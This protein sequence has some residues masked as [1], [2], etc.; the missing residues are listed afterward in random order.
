M[1]VVPVIDL[2]QGEVV[3]ARRGERARYAPLASRLCPVSEPLAVVDC[4]LQLYAWPVLYL[5]DLDAIEGRGDH[6]GQVE[7][8][9]ARWPLLELWVDAG[10]RTLE[11]CRGLAR[12]RP[13]IG[14][15]SCAGAPALR[16]A[17]RAAAPAGALLSLDW[18]GGALLGP[19]EFG[20]DAAHWP[21]EVL[22]MELDR[23]G[24][25]A[26]PDLERLRRLRALAGAHR[27]LYAAGGV[28]DRA[29]LEAVAAL[30]CAGALVASALHEGRLGRED[31]E[32]LARTA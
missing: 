32:A 13:V 28:R 12:A 31:L 19:E 24:A 5:A 29:D 1:L 27:R 22:V 11:L 14:S 15:E 7:D 21:A 9:A 17:L 8:L 26:G 4:L 18:R 30:G 23:V 16:A 25:D 2:R 20:R 10:P 6:R 3:H